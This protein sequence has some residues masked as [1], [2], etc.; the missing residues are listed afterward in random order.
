MTVKKSNPSADSSKSKSTGSTR[1]SSVSSGRNLSSRISA[2]P[3]SPR[4][5]PKQPQSTTVGNQSDDMQTRLASLRTSWD[6][7]AGTVALAAIHE[8]IDKVSSRVDSVGRDL[9]TVRSRGYRY[10]RDWETQ[11]TTVRRRWPQQRGQALQLLEKERRVLESSARD[12]ESMLQRANRDT[13]LISTAE[14]RVS[15]LESNVRQA[16]ARVRQTFDGIEKQAASLAEEIEGAKFVLDSLDSACFQLVPGEHPI[17]ACRAT[18]T[19]DPQGPEGLFFL[20]DARIIFEQ[21]QEVAKKKVLFITTQKELIQNKLWEAPIGS[22]DNVEIEDQ[23][24]FL[25]RKE[26]LTLR[27]NERTREIP[28]D[29]TLQLRGTTNEAWRTLL[30]RTKSGEIEG[31]RFGAPPPKEQLAAQVEAETMEPEKELPT[32]CPSCN[33]PLPAIFKGMR[34]VRCDYCDAAINL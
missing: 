18:W 19:S 9:E 22:V 13:G 31:D 20:S 10:G 29:I 6:R 15:D 33:A 8:A 28:S 5:Q 17:A 26:M 21:R 27:F 11:L 23:K 34:Q 16:E 24:A 25:Q 4:S 3:S 30:R 12:I 32:V 7:V 2:P 1:P 14:S